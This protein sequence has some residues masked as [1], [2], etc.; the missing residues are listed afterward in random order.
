[1]ASVVAVACVLNAYMPV[2][3]SS[4]AMYLAGSLKIAAVSD[5]PQTTREA[6]LA[7][8]TKGDVQIVSQL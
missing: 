2:H 7:V 8:L 5:K 1:M 3:Q 4:S 6:C